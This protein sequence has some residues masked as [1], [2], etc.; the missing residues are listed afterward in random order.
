LTAAKQANGKYVYCIIKSPEEKRSFGSIGFDDGEVYTLD[1]RDF[2]PVVSDAPMRE[3]EA[4]EE[5][6][7][8]HK[9]VV[10]EVM[11]EYTVLPVAY[12]MVFKN[13]N[14][15]S[16]AM[17]AGYKAMKKAIEVVDNR[18]ELGIKVILPKDIN[19]WNGNIN[20]CRTG[21]MENLMDIAADSKELKLFSD[22][23]LLNSAF[24]V[25]RNK[26][27][28]FSLAVGRLASQYKELRTQ[29]SGPWPPYNFVDIHILGKK[30]KGFR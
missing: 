22:R 5:E 15:L 27:D 25:E 14:L 30:S 8:V 23:L 6:V 1:Y 3:Y 17:K 18:V 29:Y 11:K 28:E 7:E 16:V 26:I 9:K 10:A 2:A 20:L 24:L 12:G 13:R 4:N 19:N 21:F